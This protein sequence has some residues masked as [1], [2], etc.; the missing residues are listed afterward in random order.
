MY[1]TPQIAI[2]SNTCLSHKQLIPDLHVLLRTCSCCKFVEGA[3]TVYSL[4]V[5]LYISHLSGWNLRSHNL[6]QLKSSSRS[7]CII[8]MSDSSEIVRNIF[9]SSANINASLTTQFGRSLVNSTK[10]FGPKT[11]PCGMPLVTLCHGDF[12]PST[13]THWCLLLKKLSIQLHVL[14]LIP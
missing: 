2:N 6:L 9:V 13:C 4:L 7:F 1:S 5:K 11:N 3:M 14:S 12:D 10:R 8:S